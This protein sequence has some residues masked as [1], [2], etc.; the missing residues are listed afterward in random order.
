MDDIRDEIV[1]RCGCGLSTDLISNPRFL[2][3]D[4]N[5]AAVSFRAKLHGSPSLSVLHLRDSLHEWLNETSSV[6]FVRAIEYD[7]NAFCSLIL[8]SDSDQECLYPSTSIVTLSTSMAPT[9]AGPPYVVIIVGGAASVLTVLILA[10]AC[11][12]VIC[13]VVYSRTKRPSESLR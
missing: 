4:S 12:V 9:T 11:G 13:V 3:L 2:C 10:V 1:S 5:P 6:V 8:D 7:I